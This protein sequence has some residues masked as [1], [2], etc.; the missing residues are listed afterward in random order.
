MS[1]LPSFPQKSQTA[2]R[3]TCALLVLPG[4]AV[5]HHALFFPR[6]CMWVPFE[7]DDSRAADVRRLVCE[8]GSLSW[9]IALA[10]G[11]YRLGEWRPGMR[12]L[13]TP[14]VPGLLPVTLWLWDLPFTRRAL[15]EHLHDG[16]LTVSGHSVRTAHVYVLSAGLYVA[17]L[18]RGWRRG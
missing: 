5:L 7:G 4:A 12:R 8:D 16:K 13:F 9:A 17:L 15:C 18:A 2:W 6:T 11:T 10:A 1:L 3:R 14:L